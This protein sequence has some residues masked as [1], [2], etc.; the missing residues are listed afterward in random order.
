MHGLSLDVKNASL[1]LQLLNICPFRC[2][3]FASANPYTKY[4][5]KIAYC[6]KKDNLHLTLLLPGQDKVGL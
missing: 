5:F 4:L 1:K 3:Y 2:S 6:V